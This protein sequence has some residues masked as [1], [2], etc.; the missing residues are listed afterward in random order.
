ME[1][2]DIWQWKNDVV[3]VRGAIGA[4]IYDFNNEDV[5]WLDEEGREVAEKCVIAGQQPKTEKEK[6]FMQKLQ[7]YGLYD[8]ETRTFIEEEFR[9]S[10]L[11]F[12]WLELTQKCNLR[13]VHC[14]E[15][16]TH[17]CNDELKKEDWISVL[18]T[19]KTEGCDRIQFIGGEPCC[20][21]YLADLIQCAA[22]LDFKQTELFTNATI[23]NQDLLDCCQKHTVTVRISLY[24]SDAATHEGITGVKGS[25]EKTVYWI[26]KLLENHVKVS[27]AIV[28]MKENVN[29]R[30]EIAL[31]LQKL[32]VNDF[33]FDV[34]RSVPG[35]IQSAHLVSEQDKHRYAYRKKPIFKADKKMFYRAMHENM[36]WAGKIAV[37]SDGNIY[38]CVFERNI[39]YGNIRE[40]S[41]QEILRGKIKESCW[42]LHFGMIEKCGSCEFRFACSDCRALA[43]AESGNLYAKN[44]RC[45]YDPS[46][47]I[48]N[49]EKQEV[50]E[51]D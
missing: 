32:G 15:G 40:Q 36:C 39:V 38:P 17:V 13:C 9:E 22:T 1:K 21:P 3:Y 35:G 29:K 45:L 19:L 8:G 12:A 4:A 34:I 26:R 30:D 6:E 43:N 50:T 37:S 11:N 44:P 2:N 18:H 42:R 31:F 48:W 27:V 20:V 33:K 24:G 41:L 49:I 14:Y 16:P 51:N 47:G 23:F 46:R 10:G 28:L 7:E 25:F 5:Y